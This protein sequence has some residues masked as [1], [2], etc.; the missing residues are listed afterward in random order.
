MSRSILVAR[1]RGV[2]RAIIVLLMAAV[3]LVAYSS[4]ASADGASLEV[5]PSTEIDPSGGEVTVTGSGF[6]PSVG[7]FV[8]ACDP[9]VPKGGACDMANFQQPQTDAD[10][11]FQVTLKVVPKFG[12][13]DC[14][15]TPCGIQT[16]KVGDGANRT[17]ERTVPIGFAGG[18]APVAGWPGVGSADADPGDTATDSAGASDDGQQDSA[19][20]DSGSSMPLVIGVIAAV[21]VIGAAVF[22]IAR[23]RRQ[24]A[25][26]Q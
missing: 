14:A 11:S 7:L 5:D 12:Q 25:D 3:W 18:V 13:T 21:V 24:P 10:G 26:I 4:P 17:Q 19:D 23:R 20:E 2:G 15:K 6:E 16:S 8:V 9:S 1:S 22:V